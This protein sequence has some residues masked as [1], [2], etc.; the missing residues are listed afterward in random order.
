ME[1]FTVETSPLCCSAPMSMEPMTL[2]I[3][4]SA[5][6]ATQHAAHP[7][8]TLTTASTARDPFMAFPPFVHPATARQ[9]SA[10]PAAQGSCV[11][12]QSRRFQGESA[13]MRARDKSPGNL[14]ARHIL[15]I[16]IG[17][18]HVLLRLHARGPI[19]RFV[20]GP[21]LSPASMTRQ[22][23]ALT[24]NLG[25]DAVSIGYPG[26]VFRGRIPAEPHNLGK[27]W[28]GFDFEKA[29]GRPVKVINDAAMQAIGCYRGG[30]MLFLGLGTGLG[31]TLIVDGVVE[32]TEVGHMP[33]KRGRSL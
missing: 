21:K 10:P 5:A 30:R 14:R 8:R 6:R 22:I 23:L 29:F 31:A 15:V 12:G 19:R 18:S 17:G 20:S 1:P 13:P 16:D 28:I 24:R 25:F 7:L 33:Y 27:G 4:V 3:E 32:P 11:G 9:H 26:L 2:E